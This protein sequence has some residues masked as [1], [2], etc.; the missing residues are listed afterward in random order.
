MGI[1]GTGIQLDGALELSLGG[2][3]VPNPTGG[4]RSHP[5]VPIRQRLVQFYGFSRGRQ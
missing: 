5:T 1:D 3:P 4:C 2:R